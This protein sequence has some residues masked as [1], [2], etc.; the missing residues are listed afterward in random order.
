MTVS[1]LIWI[2]LYYF[3]TALAKV[4]LPLLALPNTKICKGSFLANYIIS[5]LNGF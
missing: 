3:A 5:S 1:R 2:R 4:V